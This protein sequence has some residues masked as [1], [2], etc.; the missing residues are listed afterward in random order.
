MGK[1]FGKR[2][3]KKRKVQNIK[4]SS[5]TDVDNVQNLHWEEDDD[6]EREMCLE[7]AQRLSSLANLRFVNSISLNM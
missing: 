5:I 7:D 2:V 1:K 6:S 3:R 4:A